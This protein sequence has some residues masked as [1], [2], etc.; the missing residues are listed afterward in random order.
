[1]GD[2]FPGFYYHPSSCTKLHYHFDG[3]CLVHQNGSFYAN[4]MISY[5]SSGNWIK[6]WEALFHLLDICLHLSSSHHSWSDPPF[7]INLAKAAYRYA[8]DTYTGKITGRTLIWISTMFLPSSCSVLAELKIYYPFPVTHQ[9]KSG[10]LFKMV[11]SSEDSFG[12]F[13]L[14]LI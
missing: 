2:V 3:S 7:T 8:A 12:I 1:M 4:H 9:I 10:F 14:L 6:I 5:E 11:S 13:Q